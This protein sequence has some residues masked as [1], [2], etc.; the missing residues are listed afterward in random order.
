MFSHEIQ[1]VDDIF[2]VKLVPKM[3][4]LGP[5]DPFHAHRVKEIFLNI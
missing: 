2:V 4:C 1:A 3:L 5:W